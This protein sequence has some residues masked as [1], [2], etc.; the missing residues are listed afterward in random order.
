[1]EVAIGMKGLSVKVTFTEKERWL[2]DVVCSHSSKSG[3]IKDVLK[4]HEQAKEKQQAVGFCND[5]FSGI[6]G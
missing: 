1:M 2:Y 4:E 3:Y 5:D 6:L